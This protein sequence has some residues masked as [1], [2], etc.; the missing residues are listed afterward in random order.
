MNQETSITPIQ[1]PLKT[2]VL[3]L[4]FN[5][6]DTTQQVFEAIRQAKPPRLY[7]A[8]DGARTTKVGEKEK[9]QTVR[10]YI[11]T[12]IDWTCE[13]KTLFRDENLGCK[14]GVAGGINWFF[15]NEE[16]GIILEDDVVPSQDFF[17]FCDYTLDK[18]RNDSR[19]G[20]ITGTNLLGGNVSSNEYMYTQIFSIW[21]WAT[22]KRAWSLYSLELQDWPSANV[23]N[24]LKYRFKYTLSYY[25][26]SIFNDYQ[27]RKIDTW[28][29]QWTYSCLINSFMCITPTANLISN[30]GI[31]GTHSRIETFAN[32]IPYGTIQ[33]KD[34]E[35]PKQV[36][37]NASFEKRMIHTVYLP[38]LLISIAS[39]ISEKLRIKKII[40]KLI[41]H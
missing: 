24:M 35:T 9:V 2:A 16:E 12:S 37:V 28:D 4:V 1:H 41:N 19:I 26:I 27:H 3:F 5:R 36:S 18:Y 15:E 25:Y 30:I 7:I 40:L 17:L 38:A 21:G 10:D 11:M 20:M 8:A 6:L 39:R 32:N 33:L 34:I 13:V 29:V 14:N 23:A 31:I 22:W